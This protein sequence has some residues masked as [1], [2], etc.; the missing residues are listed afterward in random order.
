MTL[1]LKGHTAFMKDFAAQ[2]NG[3]IIVVVVVVVTLAVS[4]SSS[5]NPCHLAWPGLTEAL[6]G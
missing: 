3:I 4:S 6:A 2:R 1:R 5:S